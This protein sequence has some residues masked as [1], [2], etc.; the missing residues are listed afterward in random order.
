MSRSL[1]SGYLLEELIGRGAMGE[2][3]R[4]RVV[5]TGELIAAKLLRSEYTSDQEVLSRFV[6]ERSI[7]VSLR[8]PNLVQVRD[9]VIEGSDLAIILDYV[10]GTDLR[11]LLDEHGPL[12]PD[13]AVRMTCE[14]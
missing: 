11:R 8:H 14:V 4:G 10:E 3:H 9:L 12:A 2:V 13:E 7:L 1:G 5:E 6:Q